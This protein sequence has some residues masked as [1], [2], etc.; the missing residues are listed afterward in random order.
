VPL[1]YS[2]LT[3]KRIFIQ[4]AIDNLSNDHENVREEVIN[5]SGFGGN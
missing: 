5:Q 3:L 4:E 2:K 1:P